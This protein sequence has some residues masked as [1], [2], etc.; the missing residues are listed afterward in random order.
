MVSSA[1]KALV[2]S[3]YLIPIAMAAIAFLMPLKTVCIAIAVL[4]L[5]DLITGLLAAKKCKNP[6][7]S[8]GLKRTVAKLALYYAAVLLGFVA[9]QYL[10]S[11]DLIPI[12]KLITTLIGAVELKSCLENLDIVSGGS[13]FKSIIDKLSQQ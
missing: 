10:I 2:S 11:P 6:I 9:G 4:T 5:V 12:E 1:I 13:F 8:S 3:K 7:T